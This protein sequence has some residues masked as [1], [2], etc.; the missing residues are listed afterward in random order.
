MTLALKLKVP[1]PWASV[2]VQVKTPVDGSI[3]AP[4]GTVPVS[5]RSA[6]APDMRQ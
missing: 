3:A 5:E 2:G 1:G 6:S 4:A